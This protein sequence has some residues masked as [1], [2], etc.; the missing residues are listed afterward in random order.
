MLARKLVLLR[1]LVHLA[2]VHL[3]VVC[4]CACVCVCVCVC[5]CFVQHALDRH[6]N[7]LQ[8]N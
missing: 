6:A 1:E 7:L 4:V 5:V 2:E 8:R 3:C